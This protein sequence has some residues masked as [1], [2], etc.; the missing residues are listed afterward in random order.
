MFQLM[1]DLLME[2]SKGATD[3]NLPKEPVAEEGEK[4]I[5]QIMSP[6]LQGL[7]AY[8][9]RV[10]QQL[11]DKVE[12]GTS[13]GLDLLEGGPKHDPSTCPNCRFQRELRD[14]NQLLELL[15]KF[16][17]LG[18][19]HE[20]SAEARAELSDGSAIG[21]RTDWQIVKIL[22]KP[23][24]GVEIRIINVGREGMISVADLLRPLR[25]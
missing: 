16:F 17:W 19:E 1:Q 4:V 18:V 2:I 12:N 9:E 3:G 21:I 15:N 10:H 7:F 5:G 6:E 13:Q 25:N 23:S 11:S 20:L 22:P 14:M 24:V 8:R